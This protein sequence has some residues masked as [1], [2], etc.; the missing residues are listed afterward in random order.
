MH[1][2]GLAFHVMDT[3][4]EVAKEQELSKIGSV[5]LEIGQVSGVIFDYL[6]DVWNWAA[7]KRELFRGCELRC[8]EIHAITY[9]RSCG[10]TYDTVPQGKECPYCHSPETELAV[11]NEFRIKEI[12][13]C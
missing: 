10:R 8:E 6:Q 13:A 4:E 2:L 11:G 7:E 1:E 3:L 5:T 12:E 9:C